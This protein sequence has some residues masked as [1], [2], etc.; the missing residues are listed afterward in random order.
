MNDKEKRI[1]ESLSKHLQVENVVSPSIYV[2]NV[3]D[4]I[5]ISTNVPTSTN[6]SLVT[7]PRITANSTIPNI[8]ET[9]A[10]IFVITQ[11]S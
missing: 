8:P 6:I 10:T 9:P 2:S 4:S 11:V 7:I 5:Q 1:L 3:G